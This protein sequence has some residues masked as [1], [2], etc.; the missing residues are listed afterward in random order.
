M[1]KVFERILQTKLLS[2]MEQ[3]LSPV[4]C[5]Y[6]KSYNTQRA[7]VTLIEKM[8]ESL[9]NNGLAAAVLMEL[10]KAFL[11]FLKFSDHVI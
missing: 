6:R 9:D 7:L 1:S 2:Y 8:K 3:F 10:P 11:I 4:L 5:N